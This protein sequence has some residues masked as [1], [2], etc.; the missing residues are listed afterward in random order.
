MAPDDAPKPTPR[1]PTT[2]TSDGELSRMG[3]EAV[4]YPPDPRLDK[5]LRGWA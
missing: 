4:R 2:A 5:E 3:R 1:T